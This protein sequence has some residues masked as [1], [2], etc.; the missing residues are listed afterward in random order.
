MFKCMQFKVSDSD[1]QKKRHLTPLLGSNVR[2][3]NVKKNM[4]FHDLDTNCGWI[5]EKVGQPLRA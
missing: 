3:F 1:V 4:F 2:K 5:R